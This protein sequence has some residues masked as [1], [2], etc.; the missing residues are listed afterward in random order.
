M[1]AHGQRDLAVVLQRNLVISWGLCMVDTLLLMLCVWEVLNFDWWEA[2][3]IA[4]GVP[5]QDLVV[6]RDGLFWGFYSQVDY[7]AV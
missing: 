2:E 6:V 1:E 5:V 7:V 4:E 3:R